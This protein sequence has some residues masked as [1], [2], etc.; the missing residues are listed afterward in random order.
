MKNL[1]LVFFILILSLITLSCSNNSEKSIENN[2]DGPYVEE[3][4]NSDSDSDQVNVITALGSN[5]WMPYV[6]EVDEGVVPNGAAFIILEK[7]LEG[8]N[9]TLEVQPTIPWARLLELVKIQKIDVLAGI[10]Y[11]SERAE[12]Y[13][14]SEPFAVDKVSLF[15]KKGNEFDFTQIEDLKG[16]TALVLAGGSYGDEFDAYKENMII[17]N[18]LTKKE[19][20]EMLLNGS[21]DFF[22]SANNDVITY[23]VR[24]NLE[25]EVITLDRP[26]AENN[27]YYV[28]SK[29]NP[30]ID[31]L[32]HI[33]SR[34]IEMR[35]SGELDQ[36][37]YDF[38][39]SAT[40]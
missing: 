15:V 37:L 40:N 13:E 35:D 28:M 11:N 8:T 25:S 16:K 39:D 36:I 14:Y 12:I 24:N 34:I 17:K 10:Y 21:G 30:H 26:I 18:P 38:L 19:G 9:T 33:N 2:N 7:A 20:F 4:I 27:V 29:D 22:I 1:R 23:L 5:G 3:D 6:E 32:P 31:L